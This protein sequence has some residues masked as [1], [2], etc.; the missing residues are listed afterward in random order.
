MGYGIALSQLFTKFEIDIYHELN[1]HKLI[2]DDYYSDNIICKMHYDLIE[3][4]WVKRGMAPQDEQTTPMAHQQFFALPAPPTLTDVM[5]ELRDMRIDNSQ[6]FD[7]LEQ[8]H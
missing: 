2:K 7:H 4:R 1:V 6:H 8:R 3:G 5:N